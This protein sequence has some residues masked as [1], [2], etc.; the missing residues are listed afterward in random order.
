MGSFWTAALTIS[1][2]CAGLESWVKSGPLNAENV[3][4]WKGHSRV[5]QLERNEDCAVN[6][7]EL[8][9]CHGNVA[10]DN[11]WFCS[12]RWGGSHGRCWKA[13]SGLENCGEANIEAKVG[14]TKV[15]CAAAV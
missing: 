12:L 14:W 10:K 1:V 8:A 4:L 7:S 13:K 3:G 11:E 2:L 6:R 9:F 5:K 15:N